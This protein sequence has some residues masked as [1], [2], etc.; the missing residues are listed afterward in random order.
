MLILVAL[1]NPFNVLL[2][3]VGI[4]FIIL[5]A[6]HHHLSLILCLP[7]P[8]VI[9]HSRPLSP[10]P[11]PHCP[12]PAVTT[13]TR[14]SPAASLILVDTLL[15]VFPNT[16]RLFPPAVF[17]FTLPS[18]ATPYSALHNPGRLPI[19]PTVCLNSRMCLTIL[20]KP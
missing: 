10:T 11:G 20:R 14:P 17:T 6:R 19:S 5:V 12:P 9:T 4:L 16:C 13:H 15:A 2:F 18:S 7:P 8:A 1:D 3:L